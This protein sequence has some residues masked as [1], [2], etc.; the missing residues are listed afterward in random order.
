MN[1]IT[2]L[3]SYTDL[4][5]QTYGLW[6]CAINRNSP[7]ALSEINRMIEKVIDRMIINQTHG[8]FY[9]ARIVSSKDFDKIKLSDK[10]ILGSEDSGISGFCSA[11]MGAP[12]SN[13]VENGRANKAKISYLYLASD[14][15]TACSE[16]QPVCGDFISVAPFVLTQETK[17]VDLRTLPQDLSRFTDNDSPDKLVDI[18]FTGVLIDLFSTPVNSKDAKDHYKFSQYVAEYLEKKEIS[19]LIYNSSHNSTPGS[20][21]LVLFN[22]SIARCTVEYA[23][24]MKCL[25]VTSSFQN[26]SKNSYDNDTS[27]IIEARKEIPPYNWATTALLQ[28]DLHQIQKRRHVSAN[29][30]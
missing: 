27:K 26:I 7:E 25:S 1:F 13:Y 12:P 3:N 24:M 11:Q 21:N 22:P 19:G 18:V 16:V 6:N 9:R 14:K 10:M 2:A 17:L 30:T 15:A 4:L 23:E 29:E 28:R 8:E 20:F 5:I